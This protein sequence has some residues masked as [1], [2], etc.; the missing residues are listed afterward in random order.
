MLYGGGG[1]LLEQVRVGLKEQNYSPDLI[2]SM[3]EL[4]LG[5]NGMSTVFTTTEI[6]ESIPSITHLHYIDT[7]EITG[8]KTFET[9]TRLSNT[10]GFP[11]PDPKERHY[12]E[13]SM[14]GDLKPFVPLFFTVYSPFGQM[15]LVCN[16][17]QTD[18][19]LSLGLSDVT[20]LLANDY[21]AD[22]NFSHIR[23]Y[24]TEPTTAI[25]G[26]RKCVDLARA[27]LEALFN[28]INLEIKRLKRLKTTEDHILEYLRS[29]PELAMDLK[30]ILDKEL[31]LVKQS[32]PELVQSWKHYLEF[33]RLCMDIG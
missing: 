9:L 8:A 23:V 24:A 1:G 5:G 25:L 14:Y 12:F 16:L 21:M 19:D 13:G 30:G 17:N 18:C 22:K 10:L 33:E 29:Q 26:Q 32:R 31:S 15:E 20:N 7:S 2:C 28:A 27:G 3:L 4:R 11:P 6:I